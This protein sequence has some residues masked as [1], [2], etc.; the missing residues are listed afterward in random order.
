MVKYRGAP[1]LA[2]KDAAELEH[3][4]VQFRRDLQRAIAP[5]HYNSEH[6]RAILEVIDATKPLINILRGQPPFMPVDP[7]SRIGKDG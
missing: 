2:S 6:S 3:R 4:V 1:A 7:S 5:L